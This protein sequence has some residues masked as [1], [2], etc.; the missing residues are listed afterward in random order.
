MY[1]LWKV[2]QKMEHI[3]CIIVYIL[4]NDT[5]IDKELDLKILFKVDI[6]FIQHYVVKRE[7]RKRIKLALVRPD[8]AL[9]DKR[10]KR[11]P[12]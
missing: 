12:Q 11:S 1:A 2:Y 8:E 10:E 3:I 4:W 9:Q 5:F 7:K 6:V